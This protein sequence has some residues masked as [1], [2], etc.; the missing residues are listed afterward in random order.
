MERAALSSAARGMM[1]LATSLVESVVRRSAIQDGK[2]STA[3]NVSA[4]NLISA[5]YPGVSSRGLS[6]AL[7][8]QCGS[9]H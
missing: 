2:A 5:G 9:F 1:P 8:K 7:Q 3:L 4:H 6:R